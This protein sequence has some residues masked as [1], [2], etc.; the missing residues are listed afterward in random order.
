M[1]SFCRA[2]TVDCVPTN[3]VKSRVPSGHQLV[4]PVLATLFCGG[5]WRDAREKAASMLEMRVRTADI[6][7]FPLDDDRL[8]STNED[9]RRS[10]LHPQQSSLRP[11]RSLIP[12]ILLALITGIASGT[13]IGMYLPPFLTAV[14]GTDL[15]P[16]VIHRAVLFLVCW[17]ACPLVGLLTTLIVWWRCGFSRRCL[18][19]LG[20]TT[21]LVVL[22]AAIAAAVPSDAQESLLSILS[23]L[24]PRP[25]PAPGYCSA[26]AEAATTRAASENGTWWLRYGATADIAAAEL[27]ARM[28]PAERRGLLNGE[29]YGLFGQAR[30]AASQRLRARRFAGAWV[31]SQPPRSRS[32]LPLH[33]ADRSW[34]S[35]V[36]ACAAR[37]C[38]RG[39]DSRHP[40]LAR[41]VDPHAGCRPGLSHE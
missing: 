14:V 41:P 15:L 12:P 34:H 8:S 30:P 9:P 25:W 22:I 37:R 26:A 19:A 1:H 32:R 4:P 35:T 7:P 5:M 13:L 16:T 36:V 33:A 18:F 29:G 27:V 2:R 3:A 24:F 17:V 21:L 20:F 23:M 39:R 11:C 31:G 40:A 38:L 28:T 10:F 6:E